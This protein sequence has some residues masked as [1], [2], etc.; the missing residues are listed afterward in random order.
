MPPVAA[1]SDQV[2]TMSGCAVYLLIRLTF[3]LPST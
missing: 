2:R 3:V 1:S